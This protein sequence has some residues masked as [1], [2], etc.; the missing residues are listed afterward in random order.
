MS[1]KSRLERI[2]RSLPAETDRQRKEWDRIV[3][4]LDMEALRAAF[5]LRQHLNGSNPAGTEREAALWA[6][7]NKAV[8]HARLSRDG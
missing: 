1:V 5:E 7:V 3:R 2:E 8:E 4:A 6:I